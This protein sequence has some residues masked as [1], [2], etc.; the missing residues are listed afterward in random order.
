MLFFRCHFQADLID[1]GQN[2]TEKKTLQLH[3]IIKN[4]DSDQ[5]LPGSLFL[6]S[7]KKKKEEERTP[8]P[9]PSRSNPGRDLFAL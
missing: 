1:M 2:S 8:I 7:E 5:F 4:E 3:I 6:Q 9:M